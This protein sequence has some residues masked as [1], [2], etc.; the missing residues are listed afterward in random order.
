[1]TRICLNTTGCKADNTTIINLNIAFFDCVAA[2][3]APAF[4][5]AYISVNYRVSILNY[6]CTINPICTFDCWHMQ[7]L[8]F[9]VVNHS[10]PKKECKAHR[11]NWFRNPYTIFLMTL[12]LQF[13][14]W[15]KRTISV[16]FTIISCQAT[17]KIMTPVT[18]VSG[19]IR[20]R[21]LLV[22]NL[23]HKLRIPHCLHCG[24]LIGLYISHL[25]QFGGC[26]FLFYPW[27]N[28]SY[29]FW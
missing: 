5:S 18:L 29:G 16:C 1:M 2:E 26:F 11:K 17:I 24:D 25:P 7:Y 21:K 28:V 13:T 15:W 10:F 8:S 23:S 12:T 4:I 27:S 20:N 9:E 6:S 3:T 22:I 19:R 14:C